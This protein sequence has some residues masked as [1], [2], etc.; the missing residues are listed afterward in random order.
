MCIGFWVALMH[1]QTHILLVDTQAMFCDGLRVVLE[2]QPDI[3]VVADATTARD[4]AK[5]AL[6]TQADVIILDAHLPR[7]EAPEIIKDV[8]ARRPK[9]V[10]IVLVAAPAA[11]LV[12]ACLQAGAQG[13]LLKTN[14]VTMLLD[15]IHTVMA[16]G[17]VV[18]PM[19]TSLVLD[20]YRRRAGMDEQHSSDGLTHRDLEI[21]RHL[22]SGAANREIAQKLSL[23]PQTIKNRLSE[24]YRKLGVETRTEA[25]ALALRNGI[26]R[27]D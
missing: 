16:G 20:D 5:L 1:T 14:R 9:T 18:D 12:Q 11:D 25:V 15:A 23:S 17:A 2:T 27:L 26:V 4:A 6:E 24:I 22:V 8:L 10:I 19:L 21:L 3:N 7:R 13:C